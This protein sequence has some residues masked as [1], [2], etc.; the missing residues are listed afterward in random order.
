MSMNSKGYMTGRAKGIVLKTLADEA[1]L[2][3]GIS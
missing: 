2:Y 3:A 1:C